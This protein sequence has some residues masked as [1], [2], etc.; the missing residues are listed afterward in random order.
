MRRFAVVFAL[1][2]AACASAPHRD[3]TQAID[4]SQQQLEA[5]IA[6][7]KIPTATVAVVVGDRM[8]WHDAFGGATMHTRFRGGS[9]T[10][11]VTV[12]ALM[13]LV[14]Q[15]RVALDDRVDKYLPEFPHGEITLRQLAG[16]LSGI[17]H[18]GPGEFLNKTH[19][20]DAI[21]SLRK[22][23]SDPLLSTPGEKY[24]YSSYAYDVLGAVI[25]RVSGKRFPEA[26]AALVFRPLHMNETS[27]ADDV[28]SAKF[29]DAGKEGPEPSPETD[30]S[31]RLPAGAVVTTARDF[32]R[33][34]MAMTSD[35]FLSNATRR[36]MFTSL[37]TADGKETGVGIG[38]RIAKDE[39]QRTFL[40]HGGAV[41]G[42]RGFVLVYPNER[43][44]VVILTNL[45]FARFNEKDAGEI[46]RRFL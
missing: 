42:G 39:Q 26:A 28:N 33:F 34:L 10:K 35:G 37:A 21:D 44:A 3:Y 43:V 11:L 38:W 41:T 24:F 27:F 8:V 31:D 13:R 17:R 19:Y 18:Y 14:D 30:L 1:L 23:A 45:G 16:H 22:F 7:E 12:A 29:F 25:E 6:K 32:A 46:A 4:A 2:A 20:K 15:H 5:L 9:L 40:H 36:T